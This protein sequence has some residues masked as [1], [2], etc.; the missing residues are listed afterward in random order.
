MDTRGRRVVCLAVRTF[1]LSGLVALIAVAT[2]LWFWIQYQSEQTALESALI[3][4]QDI[5]DSQIAPL[6]TESLLEADPAAVARLDAVVEPLLR[7]SIQH[8]K[9]WD[10]SNE[11][12]YSDM[13][14]AVGF[15][16]RMEPWMSALLAGGEGTATFGVQRESE[17]GDGIGG[18]F[19]EVYVR[20]DAAVGPLVFEAYFDESI[21]HSEQARLLQTMVPPV[22]LGMV[23]LLLAMLWAGIRITRR[24]SSDEAA[25][26]RRLQRAAG[27]SDLERRHLTRDPHDEAFDDLVGVA[28]AIEE[29]GPTQRQRSG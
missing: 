7:Q 13:A 2:P 1:L 17:A 26:R 19:V 11:V 16:Y 25:R 12:I 24:L 5:A 21:V 27:I 9:V 8:I 10:E 23:T 6:V 22:I 3:R 4:T 20:S 29:A 15:P 14:E 18:R 28:P